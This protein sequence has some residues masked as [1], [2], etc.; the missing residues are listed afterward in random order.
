MRLEH[1]RQV[2]LA[3]QVTSIPKGELERAL[4]DSAVAFTIDPDMPQAALTARVLLTTLRRGPGN[5]TLVREGLPIALTE[6]LAESVEAVDPTQPLLIET[7]PPANATVRV[8]VGTDSQR[9]TIRIIPEGYGAHIVGWR[10]AIVRPQRSG[11]PVGAVYAAALGAA[12]VFKRTARV[13]HDRRILHGH[14]Q[15]CPVALS[16]DLSLAPDLNEHFIGP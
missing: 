12:E 9:G 6:A 8:H 13:T 2:R 15:F 14:L 11:N 10:G 1:S 16:T 4:Q 3:N 5:L 7:R